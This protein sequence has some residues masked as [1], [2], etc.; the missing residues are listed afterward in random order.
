MNKNGVM[1]LAPIEDASS[2]DKIKEKLMVRIVDDSMKEIFTEAVKVDGPCRDGDYVICRVDGEDKPI[3]VGKGYYGSEFEKKLEGMKVGEII[4]T[5]PETELISI[6]RK[7][8]CID[9]ENAG[10]KIKRYF[11]IEKRR[12]MIGLYEDIVTYR[13]ENSEF[14]DLSEAVE[15]TRRENETMDDDMKMTEQEIMEFVKYQ[16]VSYAVIKEA[17]L[18]PD[19]DDWMS[20]AV[21][22]ESINIKNYFN[23]KFVLINEVEALNG[24]M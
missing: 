20:Q 23:D 21:E 8:V 7:I 9:A 17:G 15:V 4:D 19:P 18:S 14:G 3:A 24:Y 13:C 5:K 12:R 16:A 1:K 6:K 2:S 10:E 11:E 22:V